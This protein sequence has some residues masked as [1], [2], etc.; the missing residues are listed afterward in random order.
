MLLFELLTLFISLDALVSLTLLNIVST[1]LTR[2]LIPEASAL[3]RPVDS[4]LRDI[5]LRIL[6]LLAREALFII[7]GSSSLAAEDEPLM[8]E[9]ESL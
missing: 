8:L 4:C 9:S 1:Y 6:V 3:A 2:E 7:N 5:N